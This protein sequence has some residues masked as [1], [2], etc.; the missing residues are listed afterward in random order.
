MK[1]E[2]V[3]VC[4]ALGSGLAVGA[5]AGILFAPKKGSETRSDLKK[6]IDELVQG[7][8]NLKKE[9]VKEYIDKKAAQLKKELE[10]LDKEKVLSVA[11]AKAKQIEK[12][13]KEL[14]DYAVKKGTP[15]LEKMA[16]SVRESTIKVTD[17]VIAKLEAKQNK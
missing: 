11:K 2:N 3:K 12:E 16:I 4:V 5:A 10:E 6:K 15:A 13:A 7:A 9:D 8:K 17:D 14:V 1:K